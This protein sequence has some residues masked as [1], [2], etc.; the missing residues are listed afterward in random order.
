[1]VTAYDSPSARLAETAGM[2]DGAD[3][4]GEVD[5]LHAIG[6]G[7]GQGLGVDH[8]PTRR[9]CQVGG[10][11]LPGADRRAL[12]HRFQSSYGHST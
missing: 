6:C 7:D 9:R 12:T 11:R 10:G 4:V 8:Q 5:E 2:D 1:M 3:A